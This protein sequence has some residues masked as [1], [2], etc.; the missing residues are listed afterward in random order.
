MS[1]TKITPH[2][3][4][5]AALSDGEK[6]RP[7]SDA[8]VIKLVYTVQHKIIVVLYKIVFFSGVYAFDQLPCV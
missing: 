2:H 6:M 8:D 4:V 1:T 7:R 5:E 3:Q